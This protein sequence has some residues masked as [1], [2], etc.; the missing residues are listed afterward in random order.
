MNISGRLSDITKLWE[1]TSEASSGTLSES[2]NN[3]YL[4]AYVIGKTDDGSYYDFESYVIPTSIVDKV[5]TNTY[6]SG[7]TNVLF[8]GTWS[9]SWC[10]IRFT[11]NTSFT[12]PSHNYWNP[13]AIYG[14]GR[15]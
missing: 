3:F 12:V 11:S 13:V 6:R 10:R 1:N 7:R 2:F 14:I 4:L 15:K 9:D 5:R 8:G